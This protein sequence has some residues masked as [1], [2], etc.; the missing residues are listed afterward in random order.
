VLRIWRLVLGLDDHTVIE[1]I[2]AA[3]TAQAAVWDLRGWCAAV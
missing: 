1:D 2:E 3:V